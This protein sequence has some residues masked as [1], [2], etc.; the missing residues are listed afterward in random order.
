MNELIMNWSGAR[1]V[2]DLLV[3]AGMIAVGIYTWWVSRRQATT[4]AI[5]AVDERVSEVEGRVAQA[6]QELRHVPTHSDVSELSHRI[7]GLHGDLREIKGSL[8][9]LS[10]SVDLMNEHLI[11]QGGEK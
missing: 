4:A 11:R 2:L 1:F 3:S 7:A 8:A 5:D 9:G 10:R 6:E